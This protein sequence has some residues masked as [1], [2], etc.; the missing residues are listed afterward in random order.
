MQDVT[1][2][3]DLDGT[4]IDTA[5]DLIRATNH[6]IEREGLAAVPPEALRPW[7]SYGARRLIEVGLSVR[8]ANRSVADVD[9]ML[10][11]FLTYYEANIAVDSR[12]FPGLD[13]VLDTAAAA[14]ARLA[15]CTNKREHLSRKLL[16]A[17]GLDTRFAAIAGRDTFPVC[18][19]DPEHLFGAIRLAGGTVAGA[20]MVGDSDVDVATA[21]AAGVPV[22]A[23]TFGYTSVPIGELAAD[24]VI[25]HY[26]AFLPALARIRGR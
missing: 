25:D 15:V 9:G 8:N 3:F 21:K 12:P 2:V 24:V 11:Q 7:I 5:P 17:L 16:V 20:V 13:R 14:G 18:K 19:P 26:D 10:D 1:L 6:V 4:L 22:I 23:V